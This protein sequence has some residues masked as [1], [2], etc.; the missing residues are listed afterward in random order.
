MCTVLLQLNHNYYYLFSLA[1]QPRAN[2][3]LLVH[4]VSLLH[5]TTHHSRYDSS[6]REISSPQRPLPDNTQ[7]TQQTNIH[8][9]D[10]IRTHDRSR[11][12]DVDL[13]LRPCGHW[14]RVLLLLLLLL[15]LSS[16][17]LLLLLITTT[18]LSLGGS[19]DT[20]KKTY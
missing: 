2:Y 10:G 1:L 18:E 11:R 6:G 19:T 5:T 14:D 7:H 17:L 16:S 15:L 4:E 13:R 3:G 20:S 9:A 12:A 8:A